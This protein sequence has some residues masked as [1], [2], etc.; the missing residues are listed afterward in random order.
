MAVSEPRDDGAVL[1]RAAE[2]WSRRAARHYPKSLAASSLRP[3]HMVHY[4]SPQDLRDPR[5]EGSLL[6]ARASRRLPKVPAD[7]AANAFRF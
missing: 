7:P 2:L 3:G 1:R 5:R 6:E 4:A